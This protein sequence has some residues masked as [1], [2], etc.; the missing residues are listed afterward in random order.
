M[1][2]PD[3]PEPTPAPVPRVGFLGPGFPD[4]R[5][6]LREAMPG[7]ELVEIAEDGSDAVP[8]DVLVPLGGRVDAAVLDRA[9]PRLVQQFGVGLQG[10]DMAAARARDVPVANLPGAAGNAVAVAEMAMLLLLGV[11]REIGALA[12]SV[13]ARAV[14]R[15]IGTMVA[16]STATVLGLGA[17]GA[18]LVP[19][20]A[21]FDVSVIGVG[22]RERSAY[23]AVDALLPP[24]DVLPVDRL[25]EAL[26]RSDALLVCTPL[27]EDTRALVDA[28][29]LAALRPG[30]VVVNVGRGPVL[31]RDALRA[32]LASGHLAGAGLDVAW[33]EPI[34]PDD[35]LFEHNVLVTPHVAGVT[36]QSY[37][38]MATAFAANVDRLGR[39]E[40]LENL[41]P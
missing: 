24:G 39:G 5:G 35:P 19:R 4:V 12:E 13:A 16:G 34:D 7:V 37:R 32:A 38:R 21:A 3:G 15:P 17:I 31:D 33:E 6:K 26:A 25:D 2:T 20:L 40:P 29:R 28:G 23:P 27:T 11:R 22:R 10:V 41:H 36:E 1:R 9:R 14:G 8:V 30:A 18:A